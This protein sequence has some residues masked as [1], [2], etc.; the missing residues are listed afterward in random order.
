MKVL[1]DGWKEVLYRFRTWRLTRKLGVRKMPMDEVR[2]RQK[3]ITIV[4]VR[5]PEEYEVGHLAGAVNIPY[6]RIQ[7]D[8]KLLDQVSRDRTAVTYC[9]IGY[10]SGVV[11][12]KLMEAGHQDVYNLKWALVHW[13]NKG[14]VVVKGNQEVNRIHPFNEKWEYFITRPMT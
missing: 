1:I 5:E 9:T 14:G 13:F 8:P 4:D 3:E 7:A 6:K 2:R 11:A 10:R 12:Q